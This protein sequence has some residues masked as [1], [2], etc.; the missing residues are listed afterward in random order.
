MIALYRNFP[1]DQRVRFDQSE[2]EVRRIALLLRAYCR[3]EP[4]QL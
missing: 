4:K 3:R 2:Q 1:R